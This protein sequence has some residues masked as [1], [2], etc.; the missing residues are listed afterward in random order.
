MAQGLFLTNRGILDIHTGIAFL[1]TQMQDP[2]EEWEKLI[3]MMKYLNGR[4]DLVLM[5]STE[6]LNMLKWYVDAAFAVQDDFK[7]DIG[8]AMTMG[9]G[10]TMSM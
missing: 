7:S 1:C 4:K 9:Q 5:Q 8:M 10:A 2:K 3:R 6:Q